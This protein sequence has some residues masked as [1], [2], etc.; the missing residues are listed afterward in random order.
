[1]TQGGEPDQ[2]GADQAVALLQRTRELLLECRAVAER[3]QEAT[4]PE[5]QAAAAERIAYGVLAA[6]LE[7][8]LV[9]TL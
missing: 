5:S 7:E 2:T 6:A 4:E 8:G 1:V 9:T 3:L